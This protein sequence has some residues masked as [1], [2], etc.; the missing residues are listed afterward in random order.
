MCRTCTDGHRCSSRTEVNCRRGRDGWTETV[1]N[2]DGVVCS[3]TPI[4]RR[5]PTLDRPVVED[6]T[7]V[8]I[9]RSKSSRRATS[10]KCNWCGVRNGCRRRAITNVRQRVLAQLSVVVCA[11]AGHTC[12][13]QQRT[14]VV[15]AGDD[16]ARHSPRREGHSRK[17]G[18]H[19]IGSVPTIH[20]VAIAEL[21]E[22]VSSPTLDGVVV[23]KRT[24]VVCADGNT[25]SGATST[26][27]DRSQR[28]THLTGRVT[29]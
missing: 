29:A 21:T 15:P 24:G 9:T 18:A 22:I 25:R 3:Q 7:R 1:T 13:V 27:I 16:V 5:T 19:L 28:I 17:V 12:V 26:Q 23:K 20:R 6:Y 10:S 2:V 14:S 11:P 8:E 4:P